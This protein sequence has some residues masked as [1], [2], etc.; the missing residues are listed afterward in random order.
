MIVLTGLTQTGLTAMRIHPVL[1]LFSGAGGLSLGFE[2]AGFRVVGAID[3]MKEA[4]QTYQ[5][6]HPDTR[7][8]N[9]DIR[10]LRTE[11]VEAVVGKVDVVLGGP[12]CQ[13]MSLAGKRI[14]QDPRNELFL[15]FVRYVKH[16][17]P[18]VFVMENVPGLLSMNNGALNRAIL[19][20]F[21]DI[22][23]GFGNP[24]P[25]LLTAADYGVPQ[26][27]QRLFYIGVRQPFSLAYPLPDKTHV[28]SDRLGIPRL[29]DTG[30]VPYV[31]VEAAIGDLPPLA[32]GE[33]AEEM[34]Y[35][36]DPVTEYQV[37]M[38]SKSK[39]V[40]NHVAPNHT[41]KMIQMI[42]LAK[43]GEA[44]DPKYTDSKRWDKDRPAFTVKALGAGGGSTNRRA[45]HYRD[46]RGSTV[47]E[48]ARIQSFPDTC[49]FSGPRTAQ[50][51]QAGNA[52]PPLLALALA[53]AIKE[54]LEM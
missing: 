48:N 50:M 29:F 23:Y 41:E 18:I 42:R 47:R 31:T 1:D 22:G 36:M 7:V 53:K 40:Y 35:T 10:D 3:N 52:V 6:N 20:S 49:V 30:H 45:F 51:T 17:Q 34:D 12:P 4:C 2:M 8:F 16:F 14:V 15:D 21:S 46:D 37:M 28:P 33:G 24:N 9:E 19:D 11:D 27:R 43:P 13:G 26:L 54:S 39:K 25:V 44:V 5:R 38:R 32:S